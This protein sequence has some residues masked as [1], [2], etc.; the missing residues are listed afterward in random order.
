MHRQG[1]IKNKK[2]QTNSKL[3]EKISSCILRQSKEKGY[4]RSLYIVEQFNPFRHRQILPL[5]E[6]PYNSRLQIV[7]FSLLWLREHF[8]SVTNF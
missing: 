3:R 8:C 5:T 7:N 6:Q 1:G 2:Q 4:T